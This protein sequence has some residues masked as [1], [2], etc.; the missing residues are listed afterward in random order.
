MDKKKQVAEEALKFVG[1]GNVVGLGSGTTASEFIK[2]LGG[3]N[4]REGVVGV[5]TSLASEHL[6]R[7]SG[8]K[9]VDIDSVDW[10]DVTVDG[11]DEID[12]ELNILKGGGGAMTR[13][14]KVC[15]KS[16]QYVIIASDEKMVKK[17]PEKRG[18]PVEILRFGY[19]TTIK[20][21]EEIGMKG[22]LRENFL[23]DNGNLIC[24]FTPSIDMDIRKM[25]NQIKM[26]T[27]VIETGLFLDIDKIVLISDGTKAKRL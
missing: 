24:D 7:R 10:I 1:R 13:E 12:Q 20:E 9:T 4:L 6:A 27:G 21:I 22:Q 23:T 19:K 5:A 2:V 18:I 25:N 14:K 15:L 17:I 16:K 8:I 3:S 11:A 26:I